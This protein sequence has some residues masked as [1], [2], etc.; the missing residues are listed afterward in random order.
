MPCVVL[1]YFLV[2]RTQVKNNAIKYT[3][4]MVCMTFA[5]EE[6]EVTKYC[7]K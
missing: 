7:N 6:Q 1:A 2:E 3:V 4:K 5:V